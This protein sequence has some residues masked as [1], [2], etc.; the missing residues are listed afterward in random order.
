MIAL[1]C[2]ESV[3]SSSSAWPIQL[4]CSSLMVLSTVN[5]VNRDRDKMTKRLPRV[6]GSFLHLFSPCFQLHSLQIDQHKN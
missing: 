3:T 2:K 4:A 5:G 6:H 1:T